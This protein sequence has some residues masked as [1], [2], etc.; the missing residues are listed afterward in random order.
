MDGADPATWSA[1]E[2][3]ASQSALSVGA[4]MADDHVNV[5][6]ASDGTLY[7]AVKTSYDS[8][9]TVTIG[10]LVRRPDGTW[11]D[12][13]DVADGG[14]TR[15][16]VQLNETTGTVLVA[17]TGGSSIL[18]EESP[19][20]VIDF[21]GSGGTLISGGG[22]N[23]SSMKDN[24][25]DEL[26]VISSDGSNVYG[27]L[28]ASATPTLVAHYEMEEDGGTALVDSSTYG[29]NGTISGSPTWVAGVAGL[30]LDL[31]GS[32]DYALVPDDASLDIENEIT[33]AAW[34]KPQKVATQD[35]V[36]K[37]V[38]N[39]SEAF[40]MV[41]STN[42]YAFVEFNGAHRTQ[43]TTYYE[44]HLD[45][46]VH[47]AAT[48]DGATVRLYVDGVEEGVMPG[49]LQDHGMGED[50]SLVY[51]YHAD[52]SADPWK[53]FDPTAPAWANDLTDLSPGWGFW[54]QVDADH[55]WDVAYPAP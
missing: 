5:A 11:D 7:A 54:V 35:I 6:V 27:V 40:E 52:D 42:G 23:A 55:T 19:V 53:L 26:V 41:L 8:S 13:Y 2:V 37:L 15:P 51:A 25:S 43:V 12:L 18:Y 50:F 46:W 10:L 31:D 17:Y 38:G 20:S 32:G 3:P 9:G 22:N 4:G 34:I 47:L 14:E 48:Y 16:I 28:C 24:F 30:A 49:V 1:D 29:N 44:D 45:E 21:G 36:K 39:G 33:L